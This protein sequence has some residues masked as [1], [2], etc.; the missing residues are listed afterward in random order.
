MRPSITGSS[1]GTEST[2]TSKRGTQAEQRVRGHL[3]CQQLGDRAADRALG[4]GGQEVQAGHAVAQHGRFDGPV[5]NELIGEACAAAG[6]RA[7]R[8]SGWRRQIAV[9][10]Q[11]ACS[12]HR[13]VVREVGGDRIRAFLGKRGGDQNDARAGPLSAGV[14]F[15]PGAADGFGI[16]AGRFG[17]DQPHRL[18]SGDGVTPVRGAMAG[19]DDR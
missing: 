19:I 6:A 4:R 18:V 15:A 8:V 14:E 7:A 10:E 11:D 13:V 5:G 9:G 2:M 12:G 1:G 16:D 17:D 3:A